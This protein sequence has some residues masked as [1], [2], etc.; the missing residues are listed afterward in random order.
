MKNKFRLLLIP[1]F[2]IT[3]ASCGKKN[4]NNNSNNENDNSLVRFEPIV[5]TFDHTKSISDLQFLNLPEEAIEIGYFS[6]SNIVLEAKYTDGSTDRMHITEGLFSKDQLEEFKT[7]GKKRFVFLYK[8]NTLELKFELKEPEKP[9][10]FVVEFRD[11]NNNL[12]ETKIVQYMASVKYGGRKNLD[13]YENNR[14]YKFVNKWDQNLDYI[15]SNLVTKPA[16]QEC[17]IE[18]SFD[19]YYQENQ[20]LYNVVTHSGTDDNMKALIY[21]GRI[22]SANLIEL[23]EVKREH[24]SDTRLEFEK[25]TDYTR[26]GFADAIKANLIN[27]IL[28]PNYYHD[29]MS[30]PWYDSYV[31]NSYLLSFDPNNCIARD[32]SELGYTVSDLAPISRSN[33]NTSYKSVI[34]QMY[35]EPYNE[36][37]T[38]GNN[39]IN[40]LEDSPL[41]T[42]KLFFRA[43]LDIYLSINFKKQYDYGTYNYYLSSASLAVAY[44]PETLK[45]GYSY[46]EDDYNSYSNQVI[47][48]NATLSDTLRLYI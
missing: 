22:N 18:N 14:Y 29:Q 9:A 6:S 33:Y 31:F 16:Y 45:M 46:S 38:E 40:I 47:I 2:I 15:Y 7:P 34:Y 32:L 43:D 25:K 5:E 10:S 11:N 36:Y 26:I 1:L 39:I 42:Y 3:I 24:Y 27:N 13:Y 23:G 37:M 41:G 4:N 28:M 20:Y 44:V 30:Q 48:S 8:N 35:N 21:I 19:N 12:L 17:V